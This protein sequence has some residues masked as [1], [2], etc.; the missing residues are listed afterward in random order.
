MYR[1]ER[2]IK[3]IARNFS[4]KIAPFSKI[5]IKDAILGKIRE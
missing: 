4:T 5:V 3:D 2:D 1:Y